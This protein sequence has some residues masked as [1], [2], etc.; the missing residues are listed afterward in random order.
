[1]A[2]TTVLGVK[3]ITPRDRIPNLNVS[4]NYRRIQWS[5][6]Q[7]ILIYIQSNINFNLASY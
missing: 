1:M 7:N 2:R 3:F 5:N 4:I 6:Q